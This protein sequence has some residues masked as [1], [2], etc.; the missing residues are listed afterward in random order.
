MS[1]IFLTASA[2]EVMGDLVIHLPL[3][4]NNYK[5][6]F[7]PTAAEAEDGDHWWLDVDK[8]KLIELGFEVEEFSIT[9]M[10]P[11]DIE[12]KL[13]DKQVIFM[14]GG[15]TFHLLDQVIKT[16]FD[17][18]LQRKLNDG[19]IYIGS[20][21]GSMIM[22]KRIDLVKTIDD[23]SKAPDLKSNGLEIVDYALLPHWGDPKIREEYMA[24]FN[25]MYV[26]NLKIIP[27][28]NKQYLW[29][30]EGKLNYIEVK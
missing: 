5:V 28:S 3:S 29:F 14:A 12:I 20:S 24:G 22:G 11:E 27:I 10:K 6:A 19:I 16:G 7:I 9:G 8:N 15:N 2:N 30:D 13:A 26:E 21:A 17:K 25:D 4:P 1:Q 18:I 23:Q